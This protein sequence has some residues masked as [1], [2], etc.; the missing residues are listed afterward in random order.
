[1]PALKDL[2]HIF[3]NISQP[4]DKGQF[5]VDVIDPKSR[6]RLLHNRLEENISYFEYAYT[7]RLLE[8]G[9]QWM[10]QD[11]DTGLLRQRDD[12]YADLVRLR[13]TTLS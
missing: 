12:R 9:G 3:V 7:A 10:Q 6:Q 1:M 8:S 4:G 2:P 13:S 11:L 5:H